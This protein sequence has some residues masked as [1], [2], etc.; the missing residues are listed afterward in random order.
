MFRGDRPHAG[1]GEYILVLVSV[2]STLL[3]G[4]PL[5]WNQFGFDR[6]A[7]QAYF[8]MPVR[9]LSVVLAKNLTAV[10][11]LLLQ[12]AILT[13]VILVL[14]LPLPLPRIPEAFAVT[15]LVALMLLTP[16]NLAS[17]HAPRPIDPNQN[18]RRSAGAKVQ[19]LGLLVYP[20]I[21]V[22]VGLAYLARYAFDSERMD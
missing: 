11:F 1:R 15:L 22:P 17:V 9:F 12:V 18:W 10:F 19:L 20:V 8:V 2:Y 7:A 16:G 21:G 13:V 3:L 5:L 6:S 4:E 14:R